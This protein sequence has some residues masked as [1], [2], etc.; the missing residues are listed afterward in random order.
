MCSVVLQ[1]PF[2]L[3]VPCRL[4]AKSSAGGVAG[5]RHWL[6]KLMSETCF[7]T[8]PYRITQRFALCS[9]TVHF[10]YVALLSDVSF[11]IAGGAVKGHCQC[12]FCMQVSGLNEVVL[13][14]SEIS[15]GRLW[16]SVS[17][18]RVLSRF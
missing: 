18:C 10:G 13:S 4:K 17:A 5:D 6:S 15:K 14:G 7:P 12:C 8:A 2:L 11:I 16:Y 1:G 9:R 3:P